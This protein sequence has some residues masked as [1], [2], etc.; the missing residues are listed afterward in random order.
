MNLYILTYLFTISEKVII[1]KELK[2]I[3]IHQNLRR[4]MKRKERNKDYCI[5]NY[6]LFIIRSQYKIKSARKIISIMFIE[7]CTKL[8]WQRAL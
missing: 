4:E 7:N 1:F 2:S 5:S 8:R 3:L 6:I